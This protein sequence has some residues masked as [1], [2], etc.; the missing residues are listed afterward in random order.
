[1]DSQP[2]N[3]QNDRIPVSA[4]IGSVVFFGALYLAFALLATEF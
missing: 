2:N 3:N 1:M 4:W